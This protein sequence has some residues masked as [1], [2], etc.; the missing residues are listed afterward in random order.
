[1]PSD[2]EGLPL[3]MLE[4]MQEGVPVLASNIPPHQ[5]LI[6]GDRGMLF[7]A[8]NLESCMNSIYWAINHPQDMVLMAKQ[9]QKYVELNYS[10][11]QITYETLKIY[12]GLLNYPQTIDLNEPCSNSELAELISKK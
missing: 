10:W 11:E 12:K 2:L 1:L 4:A 9:A 7:E 3:A 6:Q 5:Q 8:G